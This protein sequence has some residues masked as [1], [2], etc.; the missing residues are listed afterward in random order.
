MTPSRFP[1]P[2]E[3][4]A[5]YEQGV[6]YYLKTIYELQSAGG[7]VGTNRLAERLGMTPASVTDMI[8][9]L[10]EMKLVIYE[11]YQGVKLTKAGQRIAIEELRHRRRVELLLAKTLGVPWNQAHAE[12]RQETG[13]AAAMRKAGDADWA[14]LCSLSELAFPL[15]SAVFPTGPDCGSAWE[16]EWLKY[17]EKQTR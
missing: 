17:D 1:T 16:S 14:L 7:Q 4:H 5:A 15:V 13:L 12:M 9:K 8:K 10:A 6:E 3:I 2:E 11:C